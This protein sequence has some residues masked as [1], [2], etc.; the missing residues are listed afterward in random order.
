MKKMS[1]VIGDKDGV[2]F[3]P[4]IKFMFWG[5]GLKEMFGAPMNLEGIFSSGKLAGK[6]GDEIDLLD[7]KQVIALPFTG[8]KDKDQKEIYAGHIVEIEEENEFGNKT[9]NIG[10]V[11]YI[12]SNCMTCSGWYVCLGEKMFEHAHE[13]NMKIIGHIF[14]HPELIPK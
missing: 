2:A 9:K 1:A 7:R 3:G 5:L 14:T 4:E 8:M 13:D 10:T 12:T 11:E 6:R